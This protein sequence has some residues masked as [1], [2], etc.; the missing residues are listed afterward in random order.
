MYFLF[1]VFIDFFLLFFFQPFFFLLVLSLL[2]CS[3][4][5]LPGAAALDLAGELTCD[6]RDGDVW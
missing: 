5:L 2:Y 4:F 1:F 6:W 3:L